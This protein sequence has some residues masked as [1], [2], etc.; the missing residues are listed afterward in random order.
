[1]HVYNTGVTMNLIQLT[2]AVTKVGED[3]GFSS[4]VKNL[5]LTR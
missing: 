4:I 5:Y 2:A 3:W 1:M